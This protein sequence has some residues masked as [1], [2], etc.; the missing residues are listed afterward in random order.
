MFRKQQR[1]LESFRRAAAFFTAHPELIPQAEAAGQ[2]PGLAT[3]VDVLNGVI[4]R[5]TE[6]ATDQGLQRTQ[7]TL[8]AKDEKRLRDTLIVHH[9]RTVTQTARSLRGVV[10]GIGVLAA[11]KGNIQ[12]GPLVR[13]AETFTRKAAL[14]ESVLVEHGLP[15]TFVKQ[16]DEATEALKQSFDA[17]GEARSRNAGATKT[18]E[19]ELALGAAVITRLD[20]ALKR[21]LHEEPAKLAEWTQA[22]RVLASTAAGRTDA[23]EISPPAAP[24]ARAA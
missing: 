22:K 19:Q 3:Q 18:L 5:T 20:A 2:T 16:L 11:P 17:R 21:L 9:I 15:R 14:Y 7:R 6:A 12:T 13:F 10:P 24:D 1:V 23:V 4:A 8:V